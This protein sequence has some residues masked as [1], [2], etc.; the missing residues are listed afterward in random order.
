MLN[1]KKKNKHMEFEDRYLSM[2]SKAKKLKL[3]IAKSSVFSRLPAR[4]THMGYDCL[5]D[6]VTLCPVNPAYVFVSG[7]RLKSSISFSL[8]FACALRYK[9]LGALLGSSSTKYL[10]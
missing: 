8:F 1:T 10:I 6:F 2:V 5:L 7:L 9:P 3:Q 4:F